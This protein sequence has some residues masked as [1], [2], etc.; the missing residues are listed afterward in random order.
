MG[1]SPNVLR[2]G[3]GLAK[4]FYDVTRYDSTYCSVVN[5]K[6][7]KKMSPIFI[8]YENIILSIP[9]GSKM[10]IASGVLYPKWSAHRRNNVTNNVI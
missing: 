6:Y 7:C 8:T 10:I 5:P 4:S 3:S 9:S 1:R 2:M